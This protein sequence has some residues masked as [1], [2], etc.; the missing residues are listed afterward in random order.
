VN[1]RVTS[2]LAEP[3]GLRVHRMEDGRIDAAS[4]PTVHP[5][6]SLAFYERGRAELW[7]GATY[8]VGPGDIVL[9]PEGVPH[10]AVSAE[11]VSGVGL[12]ACTS[13]LNGTP[14]RHLA[15]AFHAVAQGAPAVRAVRESDRERLRDAF[16]GLEAELSA[17][18]PW[19][20][21]AVDGYLAVLTA[22]VL[23]ADATLDVP[24]GATVSA[25]ALAYIMRHATDGISLADVAEH[26]H[27]SAAHTGAVVKAETGRTVVEWITHARLAAGRQLLLRSDA[28][29]EG[30]GARIGFESA[31]HFHRVFKRHHGVTP[32][33][34]RR[35]HQR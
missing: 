23:R 31:S 21:L 19:Q 33:E 9:V 17:N 12:S 32:A 4:P 5:H 22:I 13:C 11:A 1:V 18:A 27:R 26:V 2:H 34:W 14:V 3:H 15:D 8:T 24:A 28:S 6:A 25:R 20:S 35:V 29:V 7:C 10:Y 30:V 16:A